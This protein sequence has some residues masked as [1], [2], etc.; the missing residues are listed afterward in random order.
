MT[1]SETKPKLVEALKK[2][3]DSMYGADPQKSIHYSRMVN[4]NHFDRV[5]KMMTASKGRIIHQVGTIDRTDVFIP[6]VSKYKFT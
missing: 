2:T 3:I 4:Q 1:T 6:P 5:N